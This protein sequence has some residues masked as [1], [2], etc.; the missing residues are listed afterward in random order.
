MAT[1]LL[2]VG[3]E[4]TAGALDAA[5]ADSDAVD[6][7]VVAEPTTDAARARLDDGV[8]CVVVDHDPPARDCF[9]LLE[10]AECP[11]VVA[12]TDGTS[13]L[14]SDAL[15]AGAAD[16]VDCSAAED[17]VATLTDRVATVLDER[18]ERQERTAALERYERLFANLADP[19]YM[20][21]PAGDLVLVNDAFVEQ[22]GYDRDE[23]L[24]ESARTFM[25]D[26]DF[27]RGTAL[28]GELL[29]DSDQEV[30]TLEMEVVHPDGSTRQYENHLSVVLEGTEF[31]ASIGIIRGIEGR[32]HREQELE[33]YE[34]I[35]ETVPDGVFVLDESA[36]I[37]GGNQRGADLLGFDKDDLL[38]TSI[39]SLIDEGVF[40]A[41]VEDA[42]RDILPD[43]LSADVDRETG[44]FEF[45]VCPPDSDEER[46]FEA[47]I[48][49]R[50]DDESFRGTI[51]IIRD[52]TDREQRIS[53]LE[54]YETIID[55]VPDTVYA[56]DE[57]GYFTFVN[58]AAIS[59]FGYSPAA[60]EDAEIHFG[61][62]IAED[63]EKF[64]EATRHLLSEDHDTGQKATIEYTAI[65]RD[66]RRYPAESHLA[67]TTTDEGV[68]GAG[69]SRDISERKQRERRL[70]VLDRVLRHNLRN[71]LAAVIAI[72]ETIES[73]SSDPDARDRAGQ[74]RELA[75]ELA[76]VSDRIREVGS[77]IDRHGT[78]QRCI[79]AVRIVERVADRFRTAH[80]DVDITTD[81]PDEALVDGTGALETAVVN[82]VENAIEHNDVDDPRVALAV[83]ECEGMDDW[84]ELTVADNGPGIP[85]TERTVLTESDS[86]TPLKHGSGLGLWTVVWTVESFQGEVEIRDNE[87]RGSVVV[88]RLKRHSDTDEESG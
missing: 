12:T 84:V 60:I 79:G 18:E 16:Y 66:G 5:L 65:T 67:V 42:Y 39:P 87:P 22:S 24:G 29:G 82:L 71:D 57:E 38:G 47:R 81:C 68:R 41:E 8:D 73:E 35:V 26:A 3:D 52:V 19:V 72:A 46:V 6:V 77:A 33:Q 32:K 28:I 62:V 55:A 10:T 44:R 37:V 40:G 45:T 63:V 48:A 56:V 69:V 53:E 7:D 15:G 78:E 2:W 13:Q 80:P 88:L 30:A 20:L 34:T 54:R 25:S 50:P 49:L 59:D 1:C 64:H 58:E 23:L 61:E 11:V 14:A 70:D 85:D 17:A 21:D 76:T 36:T 83:R 9:S 86:I 51:G 31:V 74:I 27:D 43:L 75:N 4:D